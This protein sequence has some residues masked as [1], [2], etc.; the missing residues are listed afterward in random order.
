MDRA[1]ASAWTGRAAGGA[2]RGIGRAVPA[3]FH[4]AGE[5]AQIGRIFVQRDAE[6]VPGV[7]VGQ[8]PGLFHLPA[9]RHGQRP[10]LVVHVVGVGRDHE[11]ARRDAIVHELGVDIAV[12]DVV[13]DA[14]FGIQLRRARQGQVAGEMPQETVVAHHPQIVLAAVGGGIPAALELLAGFHRI[15]ARD[16]VQMQLVIDMEHRGRHRHLGKVRRVG[17]HQA[18][19]G[20]TRLR[21]AADVLLVGQGARVA[22]AGA[23]AAWPARWDRAP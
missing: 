12:G 17:E 13:A 23:A 14:D 2:H 3:G 15:A 16:A 19:G 8:R 20:S 1:P 10:A 18:H 5:A 4:P 9:R 7:A 11:G 21:A 22:H 6:V